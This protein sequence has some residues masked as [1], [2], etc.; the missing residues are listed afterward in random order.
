[1][2]KLRILR[3]HYDASPDNMPGPVLAAVRSDGQC[4][5]VCGTTGD[6]EAT[7]RETLKLQL[8][9]AAI[10]HIHL[11]PK[12]PKPND[13]NSFKGAMGWVEEQ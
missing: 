8:D 11:K 7:L 4:M 2:M 1:M 6:T 10:P 12:D 13:P 9:Q 3:T 5:A